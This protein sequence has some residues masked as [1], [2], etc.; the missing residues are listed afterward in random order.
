[1]NASAAAVALALP[2]SSETF[3]LPATDAHLIAKLRQLDPALLAAITTKEV[4]P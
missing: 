3:G 1:M 2:E 4:H